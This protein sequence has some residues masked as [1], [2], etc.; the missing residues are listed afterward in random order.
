MAYCQANSL[1]HGGLIVLV[2][3]V[4]VHAKQDYQLYNNQQSVVENQ[5][6]KCVN[7]NN[8]KCVN[9]LLHKGAKATGSMLRTAIG[10]MNSKMIELLLLFN[11]D[12][13]DKSFVSWTKV[14][15]S[16]ESSVMTALVLHLTIVTQGSLLG[17][18]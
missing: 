13:Y 2:S 18:S 5:L 4:L 9:I 12:P 7:F 6:A 16:V 17:F 8:T 15:Y 3:I 10:N 1:L 11:A 14:D